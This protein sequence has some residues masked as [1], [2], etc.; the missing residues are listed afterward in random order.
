MHPDVL[1][2]TPNEKGNIKIDP[3]R[4]AVERAG[5]RPFEG[6]RRVT[7]IDSADGLEISA[8]NSLLKVLEEPPASSVFIL[9]TALFFLWGVPNNNPTG[10][11]GLSEDMRVGDVAQL[12]LDDSIALRVRFDGPPPPAALSYFRGPVLS[13]FDGRRWTQQLE[14]TALSAGL[15]AELRPRGEP[16][17]Y[18]VTLEPHQRRWLFVLEAATE[19]PGRLVSAISREQY[20][21]G[22]KAVAAIV[23][24]DF[25]LSLYQEVSK[26]LAEGWKGHH[27]STGIDTG[28]IDFELSDTFLKEGPADLVAKA[29]E[30]WPDIEKAKKEIIAGTLKVPL[31]TA[32]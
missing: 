8:Q 26:A 28:V 21:L 7:I 29:K 1:V 20:K 4:E 3:V 24:L 14:P 19:A 31:N 25:G 23:K 17:R 11:S 6:R 5:Y 18:E 27:V 12:A 30:I 16:L 15:R 9:V 10:T 13:R 22:P 32:L 2:L